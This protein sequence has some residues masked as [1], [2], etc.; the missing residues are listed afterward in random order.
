MIEWR[1]MADCPSRALL[2]G[3]IVALVASPLP[4]AAEAPVASAEDLAFFESKVRPV[5]VEHCSECHSSEAGEPEGGLSF[6]SRADFFAA[7]GVAVAGKPDASL[8]VKAVRYDGDLQ[9]PPDGRLTDEIVGVIEQW[10]A[11]GLPWP[12]DGLPGH[13]AKS[14][15]IASRR[16][17]HWCWHGPMSSPLPEVVRREWCRDP[18]DQFVL[19]R[20]ESA[21]LSPAPEAP[22]AALVRRA[23]LAITGLPPSPADVELVVSD[24]DPSAFDRYVDSLL[25]SPHYGERFARHWLD[26]ARFAETRGHEFDHPI[27]NAWR[28]RDWVVNAFNDD[29]PYDQFVREQVAG[30]L[31]DR[32]R[33]NP[34]SGANLSVVGTGFWLLGE[35]VHAPVDIAQ[36]EADRIDNRLDTFGKAFLGLALGCARCHDHK[37]D[38][39]SNE[40]YYALAGVLMSSS[41]RQV[42]FESLAVNHGVMERL[43]SFDGDSQA[44]L[45]PLVAEAVADRVAGAAEML[46][47]NAATTVPAADPRNAAEIVIAD[48]TRGDTSTPIICDGIAWGTRPRHAGAAVLVP[49]PRDGGAAGPD[50]VGC[51]VRFHE[52]SSA[53][54]EAVWASTKST[55]ERDPGPLGGIDR[56]GRILRTPKVRINEG[57]IWHRV[58][59]H[60]QIVVVVDSHVLLSGGPLHGNTLV[61]V[62]TKGEWKWIRQDLRSDKRWEDGHVVHVEYAAVGGEC[63]VAEAVAS[64]EEPRRADPLVIAAAVPREMLVEETI[65]RARDGSLT[66]S[67]HAAA[68]ARTL[69]VALASVKP[70]ARP[71][72]IALLASAVTSRSTARHEIADAFR[73][74]SATA[75]ALLDGNGVDQFV[76]IKGS[77]S[78]RGEVSPRRFLEAID[79]PRQEAWPT[80]GSGRR[81]LADRLLDPA[82]P[83]TSRV[84]VNRVWHHLFGR[85]LVPTTDNFGVLGEKPADPAAQA[86]LDTL[87]VDF[88]RD[89]S[90]VKKLVRR[91]VTSATWRMSSRRDPTA[92]AKDP[93]NLLFHHHPLRRLEGEAIRDS[94]LAVS[95]RLDRTVGGPGV[96]VFLTEFHDGRGRPQGGPLDGAGRRS[97]YTRVRRNFL[98]SFL[99]VFDMPVPFQSMGRRNVT[100]VPAQ[101]LTMMN[102]PFV[103]GQAEAW[104]KRILEQSTLPSGSPEGPS[105]AG[106]PASESSVARIDRMYREAFARGPS[107]AERAA[108]RSFLVQQAA[109][110]G[111]SFESHPDDP[112]AW[113]DFAH[114]LF[115]AKEFIFVP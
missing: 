1:V 113:I 2:W 93:L 35:E 15:D 111:K 106:S 60:L 100:N 22:T 48:Y 83:L 99:V 94:M 95:G 42:P 24:S 105:V 11:R 79:G 5:L 4:A 102:D 63:E 76:L 19:A 75:P 84:L 90:S 56:A 58:R 26:V 71:P 33:I 62:D 110:H 114:A 25:A 115:N 10:V 49:R 64:P 37:F 96:E 6:D 54:S 80:E 30:D 8:I 18:L 13:A 70:E 34:A 51:G 47:S 29:L 66:K 101:S 89:G 16:A 88:T 91:I 36:D 78:R 20:L 50:G 92:A 81:Q 39:I 67:P 40:D 41:Y 44:I 7:E 74:E 23:S 21:G 103:V 43:E 77:A 108:A 109:S 38:A 3:A 57:V 85:G 72:A 82:N 31:L 107:D 27:P 68:L 46:L 98:P 86:L 9:M 59:G 65:K 53:V 28:Y 104:A 73:L 45:P 17:E 12:D 97:L 69:N 87:A 61:T 112:A 32:P 14:F 55:G 52:Q